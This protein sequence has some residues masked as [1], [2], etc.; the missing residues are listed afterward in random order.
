MFE[1]QGHLSYSDILFK[2]FQVRMK[3]IFKRGTI[4]KGHLLSWGAFFQGR[5]LDEIFYEDENSMTF[6]QEQSSMNSEKT[7]KCY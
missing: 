4:S 2:N 7:S 6:G 3:D 1:L 5:N